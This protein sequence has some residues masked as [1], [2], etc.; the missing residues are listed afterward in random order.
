MSLI[1]IKRFLN[2]IVLDNKVRSDEVLSL[3]LL[4]FTIISSLSEN[5]FKISSLKKHFKITVDILWSADLPRNPLGRLADL[6]VDAWLLL[7]GTTEPGGGDSDEG[8]AALDVDHK[9]TTA[10]SETSVLETNERK[11]FI[12]FEIFFISELQKF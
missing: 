2:K 9:R 1:K 6:V 5:R 11:R 3:D 4:Q 12:F 10:I 8:P 7:D